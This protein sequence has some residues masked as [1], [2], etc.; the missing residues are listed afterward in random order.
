MWPAR[1]IFKNIVLTHGNQCINFWTLI[2][3]ITISYLFQQMKE[4]LADIKQRIK[5]NITE[6]NVKRNSSP[7]QF[8]N[9]LNCVS[10]FL[11][12][13]FSKI[14]INVSNK[15]FFLLHFLH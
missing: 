5:T 10:V 13:E 6:S 14:I 3:L 1:K 8:E 12:E 2:L 4:E 7:Q 15:T 11:I 9:E